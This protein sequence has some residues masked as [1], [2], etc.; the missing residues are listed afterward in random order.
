MF[1]LPKQESASVDSRS[2]PRRHPRKKED[3]GKPVTNEPEHSN[4][5]SDTIDVC[6]GKSHDQD[7]L[8]S[9]QTSAAAAAAAVQILFPGFSLVQC[10][11]G[12]ASVKTE[13]NVN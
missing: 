1:F 2:P 13:I 11:D 5:H 12:L 3:A 7:S 9:R 6:G 8:G 10:H 4:D